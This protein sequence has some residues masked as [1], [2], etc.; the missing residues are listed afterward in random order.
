M[1]VDAAAQRHGICWVIGGD[2]AGRRQILNWPTPRRCDDSGEPHSKELVARCLHDQS[3]RQTA[4]SINT[5]ACGTCSKA[6]CSVISPARTSAGSAASADQH[7]IGT[8][9]LDG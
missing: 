2:A 7:P 3:S 6:S 4:T 1:R 5:A 8:L 9:L